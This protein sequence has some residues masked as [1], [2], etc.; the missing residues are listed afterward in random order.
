MACY[1]QPVKIRDYHFS[2]KRNKP[3]LPNV[4]TVQQP[5]QKVNLHTH[6]GIIFSSDCTWHDHLVGVDEWC[7]GAG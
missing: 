3:N 1:I 5:I 2:R 7:D 6:L 4:I